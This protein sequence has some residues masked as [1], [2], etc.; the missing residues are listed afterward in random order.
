VRWKEACQARQKGVRLDEGLAIGRHGGK[1]NRVALR[2]A[3]RPDLFN[4]RIDA[5]CLTRHMSAKQCPIMTSM[6]SSQ[7]RK[8][9]PAHFNLTYR[10]WDIS[11]AVRAKRC[12]LDNSAWDNR[13]AYDNL[14][15]DRHQDRSATVVR[16][17]ASGLK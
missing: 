5:A 12:V 10:V 6:R 1:W 4:V 16:S 14:G 9:C 15:Q 8:S 13:H 3:T 11:M 2:H 7:T 17:Y